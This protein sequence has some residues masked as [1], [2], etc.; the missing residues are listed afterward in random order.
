MPN[1]PLARIQTWLSTPP[2]TPVPRKVCSLPWGRC[3]GRRSGVADADCLTG[4]RRTIQGE[5]HTPPVTTVTAETPR[6]E[7][8]CPGAHLAPSTTQT[9]EHAGRE[10]GSPQGN[11]QTQ[12]VRNRMIFGRG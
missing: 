1:V 6:P 8:P 4:H 3:D 10:D 11:V 7:L 5:T 2:V 9:T 12:V